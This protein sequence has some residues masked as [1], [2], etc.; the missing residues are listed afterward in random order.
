MGHIGVIFICVGFYIVKEK[1]LS[2][3]LSQEHSKFFSLAGTKIDH[4]VCEG[5]NILEDH[6]II[7]Y[8]G[9]VLL[10]NYEWNIEELL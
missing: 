5:S 7:F 8:V 3:F 1:V 10:M 4:I 2:I 9:L 6:F